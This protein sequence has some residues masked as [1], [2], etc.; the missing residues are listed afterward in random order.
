MTYSLAERY[1]KS[2]NITGLVAS[3][4]PVAMYGLAGSGSVSRV[5]LE[6]RLVTSVENVFGMSRFVVTTSDIVRCVVQWWQ[7]KHWAHFLTPHPLP[8]CWEGVQCHPSP[9]KSWRQMCEAE[10][11]ILKQHGEGKQ[12]QSAG[13]L[14]HSKSVHVYIHTTSTSAL[15]PM[16][17]PCLQN[18][19]KE[20]LL[21]SRVVIG[22]RKTDLNHLFLTICEC[23]IH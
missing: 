22:S 16:L 1:K 9:S 20:C 21:R 18:S 13:E 19:C 11:V 12:K 17:S 4:D 2:L 3:A 15:W 8:P 14:Y 6:K 5:I 23:D 10:K 7:Y